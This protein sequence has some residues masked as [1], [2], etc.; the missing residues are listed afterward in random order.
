MHRYKLKDMF[1]RLSQPMINRLTSTPCFLALRGTTLELCNA[2][3]AVLV[4]NQV[5]CSILYKLLKR[6]IQGTIIYLFIYFLMF[7]RYI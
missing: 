4:D 2:S 6:T 3:D 7:A 1:E 5:Y